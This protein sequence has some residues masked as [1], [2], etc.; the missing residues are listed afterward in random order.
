MV[1]LEDFGEID[2]VFALLVILVVGK[3][4]PGDLVRLVGVMGHVSRKATHPI[5]QL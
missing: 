2:D 3:R 4:I 1:S 5:L